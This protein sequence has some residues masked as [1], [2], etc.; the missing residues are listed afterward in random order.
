MSYQHQ[1]PFD[2]VS[3][4]LTEIL[5]E[6]DVFSRKMSDRIN[7]A[8]S[9]LRDAPSSSSLERPSSSLFDIPR[10]GAPPPQQQRGVSSGDAATTA[11]GSLLRSSMP[12]V[13]YE[14]T[15]PLPTLREYVDAT[16]VPLGK[17]PPA[18]PW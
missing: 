4:T 8:A 10:T 14:A 13:H 12:R 18:L 5:R 15:S 11:G 9:A 1:T 6:H 2:P 17:R 7:H 16:V 3:Y